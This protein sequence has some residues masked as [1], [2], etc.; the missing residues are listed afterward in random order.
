[1]HAD[2]T[3]TKANDQVHI[4]WATTQHGLILA[5]VYEHNSYL[6]TLLVREQQSNDIWALERC[7]DQ[8]DQSGLSIYDGHQKLK[9][10]SVAKD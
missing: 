8:E 4:I 5:F 6:E 7:C 9:V 1:M 10:L 3:M 2:Q